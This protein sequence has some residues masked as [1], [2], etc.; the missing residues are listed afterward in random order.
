MYNL[1]IAAPFV[2][3]PFELGF[4]V[5]KYN[6]LDHDEKGRHFHASRLRFEH[7]KAFLTF[8]QGNNLLIL[9]A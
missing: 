9:V 1:G 2:C 4:C 7:L 5:D 8:F 6:N 3:E